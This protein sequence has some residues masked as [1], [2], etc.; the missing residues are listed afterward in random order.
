MASSCSERGSVLARHSSLCRSPATSSAA[1]RSF[2]RG[3]GW[4]QARLTGTA[5]I[6]QSLL[7]EYEQGKKTLT[8]ERLLHLA[9][10]MDQG[11]GVV[12][13][14]LES[15]QAN[16]GAAG[17]G[18]GPFAEHRR[19]EEAAVRLGR[20][21]AEFGRSVITVLSVEGVVRQAREEAR[22][23]WSRLEAWEPDRR[24]V[25]VEESTEFRTWALCELV[26]AKSIEAA[27]S[28]PSEA[29]E[30]AGLALNIAER[31][32]YEERL[33]QRTEG[34]AWFHVANARRVTNDLNSSDAALTKAAKL[35]EAGASADPGYF[36]MAIPLALEASIRKAQR[37]FPIALKRIE[38]AL[39]TDRGDLRGRLLL[40]KA[41]LLD[42]LGELENSTEVLEEAVTF[43]NEAREPRVALGVRCELLFNLCLQG[44]A[45][46]A[47]PLLPKV[48]ALALRI[49][50]EVDSWRVNFLGG[51]IA[52]G[53]GHS[54]DAE[55][56]FEQVRRKFYGHKPQLILDYAQVSMELALLLL[57]EGRS[58]EAR[59]LSDQMKRIFKSQGVESEALAALKVFCE[60]ARREVATVDLARRVI[61][62]LRQSQHD[63]GLKFEETEEAGLP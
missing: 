19:G 5:G 50:T 31:C 34:Y 46:E 39:V 43:I 1:S 8:R 9:G 10:L 23:L 7:N 21:A 60:A 4:S 62:F 12:D 37:R 54:A 51:I 33:R 61:R 18:S 32:P 30:L 11:A 63:P 6:P 27:P 53:I 58:S 38:E 45:A 22:S 59:I 3:Q 2:P 57:K 29:L 41:Q 55:E 56:T 13:S 44:R 42:R 20:L 24:P 48:Q 52:A 47:A 49:G 26:A 36:N 25:L 17:A 40:Q 16:R 15:L 14:T 35:W 28:S